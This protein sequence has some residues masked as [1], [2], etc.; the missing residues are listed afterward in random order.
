MLIIDAA[1]RLPAASSR[2]SLLDSIMK[3][4]APPP[5][6]LPDTSHW[7]NALWAAAL[8]AMVF[9]AYWPA[10]NAGFIWDDDVYVHENHA[11]RNLEGLQQIWLEPGVVP[12]YYPLVHT[13]FW[14]E[15]HVWELRTAGYHAVN[16]ALHGLAAAL[17]WIVL[18]RLQFS[19]AVAWLAAAVFALHPVH[20]ESVAWITERKNVLSLVFYLSALLAYMRFANL[21]APATAASRPW[22]MYWLSLV[23]FACALLSK[24]VT[25]SLPAAILLLVWWKRGR[26]RR[27]DV[28]PLLPMFAMGLAMALVTALM[29]H[30]VVGATG[31][32]WDYSVIE[33]ILIAG[34][35]AWFYASKILWPAELIF[36]YPKWNIDP[37]VAW[38][39][40]FPAAAVAFLAALW[41]FRHRIGPALGF[42]N[43]FPFRYSLVADHFQYHASIGL[44]V[45]VVAAL[46]A[47]LQRAGAQS[48][49][50]NAVIWPVILATLA[51]LTWRQAGIYKDLETLWADTIAK[52][53]ESFAAHGN[54]G[55]LW[56]QRGEGDKAIASYERALDIKPDLV[57]AHLSLGI[58]YAKRGETDRAIEHFRAAIKTEPNFAAA[59]NG[60]GAALARQGKMDDAIGHLRLAVEYFP[61]FADAHMNLG[62]A[63]FRA[64]E[65]AEAEAHL[66]AAVAIAPDEA[67][68]RYLLAN[69]LL[70]QHRDEQA[71]EQ[72]EPLVRIEPR[73]AD[74]HYALGLA[75]HRM[76]DLSHAAA[77]LRRHVACFRP[78]VGL[79]H[80]DA[81]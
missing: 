23:L 36:F 8:F 19:S 7:R 11:L 53:P 1:A 5:T 48:S 62:L 32:D 42:F 49:A 37:S 40:I 2:M 34:R 74:A 59:H 77:L 4:I 47:I 13:T 14:I 51:T 33:R 39:Y 68:P 27:A 72:F 52:N 71:I 63:L 43:V 58:E 6:C 44:I 24:S 75:C 31:A 16:I 54:M 66:R 60:L 15:Y 3:K 17:L 26:I 46:A 80:F 70:D 10:L 69:F 50:F 25:C 56:L 38:Q 64:G 30:R 21:D 67:K 81:A 55:A 22:R 29:E 35:A 65:V 9:A 73:N 45:L 61:Q 41:L 78:D 57:E 28:W 76:G 18:R 79:V 12:Q 20:V